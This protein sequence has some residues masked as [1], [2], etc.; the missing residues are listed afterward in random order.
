MRETLTTIDK[1]QAKIRSKT[2]NGSFME[3]LWKLF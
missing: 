3:A 2:A 1:F